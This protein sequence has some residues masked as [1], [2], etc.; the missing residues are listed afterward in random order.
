MAILFTTYARREIPFETPCVVASDRKVIFLISQ[1]FL[2]NTICPVID[3]ELV[4]PLIKKPMLCYVRMSSMTEI[5]HM[6][7]VVFPCS[8]INVREEKTPVVR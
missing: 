2:M 4:L 5:P 7:L 6:F 8:M 1:S 3:H